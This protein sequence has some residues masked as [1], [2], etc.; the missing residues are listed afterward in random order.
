MMGMTRSQFRERD[1]RR[2][3]EKMNP[4]YKSSLADLRSGA[5]WLIL[6]RAM[7][8]SFGDS[9]LYDTR[10]TQPYEERLALLGTINEYV[11]AF[12]DKFLRK[13]PATLLDSGSNRPSEVIVQYL[14]K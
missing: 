1:R 12:F 11:L 6:P 14:K 4:S 3:L 5:Y 7:H 9:P 13:N 10:S 2:I 8:A